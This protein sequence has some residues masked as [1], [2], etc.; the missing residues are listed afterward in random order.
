MSEKEIPSHILAMLEDLTADT[1]RTTKLF[2]TL[3]ELI[4][5]SNQIDEPVPM[6]DPS[7]GH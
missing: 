7:A 4:K 1:E 6:T 2:A 3:T 5:S